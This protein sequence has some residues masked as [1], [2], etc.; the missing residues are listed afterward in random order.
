MTWCELSWLDCTGPDDLQRSWNEPSQNDAPGDRD[1]R[2]SKASSV[3]IGVSDAAQG[4]P[5]FTTLVNHLIKSLFI[6][7][8]EKS[9][10][11]PTV[12]EIARGRDCRIG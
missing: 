6:N 3:L 11:Y 5:K 2:G 7:L 10:S 9:A 4:C 12:S 1:S 8:T